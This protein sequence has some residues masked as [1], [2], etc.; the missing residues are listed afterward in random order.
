MPGAWAV[1]ASPS[2]MNP[3]H[4]PQVCPSPQRTL[5][6]P[7]RTSTDQPHQH[8]RPRSGT[9]GTRGASPEHTA[10][11]HT[12]VTPVTRTPHASPHSTPRNPPNTRDSHTQPRQPTTH[13]HD[14]TA[15]PQPGKPN[16][17]STQHR[18]RPP[19]PRQTTATTT[20]HNPATPAT[21][22]TAHT[23]TP[24]RNRTPPQHPVTGPRPHGQPQ[25]H[26]N[27][28]F[29]TPAP[30]TRNTPDL[31]TTRSNFF[32]P[33]GDSRSVITLPVVAFPGPALGCTS[34]STGGPSTGRG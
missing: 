21:Q 11:P 5:S 15:H 23:G 4:L 16:T 7:A 29:R 9:S 19:N 20:R 22:H 10:P 8:R 33:R 25:T 34:V 26:R 28:R 27:T 14:L 13:Q 32:L 24:R 30:R 3:E 12:P 1:G 17:T 6:H 31:V 2:S 18:A